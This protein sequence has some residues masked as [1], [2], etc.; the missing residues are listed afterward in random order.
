VIFLNALIG[1][2]PCSLAY[3]LDED[4]KEEMGRGYIVRMPLL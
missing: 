2:P 4:M 1:K 3:F